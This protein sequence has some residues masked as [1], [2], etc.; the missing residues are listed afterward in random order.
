M[1]KYV[2]LHNPHSKESRDFV[3]QH[4]DKQVINWYDLSQKDTQEYIAKSLPNPS[5]FPCVVD[6]EKKKIINEVADYDTAVSSL[7][8]DVDNEQ[9]KINSEARGYL[10]STDWYILREMDSG[11]ACPAEIKAERAAARARI[12]E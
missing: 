8:L 2:I 4:Q 3:T 1:D 10:A 11:V 12:V 6:T 9:L 7:I 5:V